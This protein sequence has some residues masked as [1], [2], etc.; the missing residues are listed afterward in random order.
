MVI[1]NKPYQ[2]TPAFLRPSTVTTCRSLARSLAR[3]RYLPLPLPPFA[4]AAQQ[5]LAAFLRVPDVVPLVEAAGCLFYHSRP[6]HVA[7]IACRGPGPD[8][9]STEDGSPGSRRLPH[10]TR[11][12]RG[13]GDPRALASR[14]TA[15]GNGRRDS[16]VGEGSKSD[17]AGVAGTSVEG[18]RERDGGG[19]VG[20]GLSRDDVRYVATTLRL[21]K[22]HGVKPRETGA[23]REER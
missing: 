12:K 7:P 14:L 2:S 13:A 9:I 21:R 17:V 5:S 10:N 1:Q 22:A 15:D 8:T 3:T 19:G 4:P 20:T 23:R 18:S 16:H 11:V 6:T